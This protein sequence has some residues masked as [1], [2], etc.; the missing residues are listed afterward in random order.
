MADSSVSRRSFMA[1]AA[2]APAA[3][4]LLNADTSDRIRIFD[5]P[6]A[7]IKI[8]CTRV[9]PT[10]SFTPAEIAQLKAGGNGKV[11]IYMPATA[12]EMEKLLPDCDVVFGALNAATLAK[13]K[14][15]KWVQNLQ[16]AVDTELF[17][18]LVAHPCAMTNM[19]RMY[20]PALG[21]TAM[22]LLLS[23]TRGIQ[24]YYVTQFQKKEWKPA[25]DLVEIQGK[26]MGII[27]MGGLGTATAKIAHYGFDMKILA[28][29]AKPIAKP[30]YVDTLREPEWLSEMAPQVDV[31]VSACPKTPLSVG[32]ISDKVIRSMKKTAYIINI[33]RGPLV[34]ENALASALKEGRIAGAGFDPGPVE[35]YP[36]TGIL[37]DCPNM[38]FTQ[39]TG[40]Y[41]PERQIR[42]M[43]LL[44]DNV[45]RY[46][47][48]LPLL[49][50][51]DK[52]RGY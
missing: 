6:P 47:N 45:R 43:G 41:S 9:G 27:A 36:P 17:P 51:V 25:R 28:V 7:S 19:A 31:L 10:A 35:P 20:A 24:K 49:N 33:S 21:E 46:A 5:P 44:A 18:E 32:M 48:G 14:N 1:A 38:I 50:V 4:A 26:T 23:L 8:L 12:A 37:W 16:A 34:D 40:G 42:H 11:E 22:A 15:L 13:S 52:A 2:A 29:D 30:P 39:H 3:P